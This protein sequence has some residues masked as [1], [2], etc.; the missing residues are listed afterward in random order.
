M[1]KLITLFILLA[2]Y[3]YSFSQTKNERTDFFSI[4]TVSPASD[5]YATFGHTAIRYNNPDLGLDIVYNYG[6][7]SYS[8]N[9]IYKF[10][11]GETYYELGVHSYRGFEA[12]NRRNGRPIIEQKLNLS[13]SQKD[14]LLIRFNNNNL[15]EN[16]T[17][18][19]NFLFDNCSSRPMNIIS[20]TL[21]NS[22]EWNYKKEFP[23]NIP[24]WYGDTINQLNKL[25]PHITWRDILSTYTGKSSWL[26]FGISIAL[27]APT[28]EYISEKDAMFLPDFFMLFAQNATN[29]INNKKVPLIANTTTDSNVIFAHAQIKPTVTPT[30]TF[31]LIALFIIA[32]SLIGF[33]KQ[34]HLFFIDS[35]LYLLLGLLGVLVWYL[36]FV[37]IHPVVFP[38]Y[39]AIWASPIHILFAILW[40]IPRLRKYTKYYIYIYSTIFLLYIISIPINPQYV[41]NGFI[42]LLLMVAVRGMGVKKKL[43]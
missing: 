19:Y 15:P 43:N 34:K 7:F 27:G 13:S 40:L 42:P 22:L 9:F 4:L 2:S 29:T 39:N 18:L 5:V 6:L 35:I 23:A 24:Y 1:K 41:H 32:I 3:S 36:S 20:N 25:F 16:R 30:L 21:G 38:N 11:K 10:T 33:K 31:W 17:Y 14:S 37:S 28:D 26:H 12:A 8:D